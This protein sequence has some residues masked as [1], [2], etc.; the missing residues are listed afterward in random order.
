[1]HERRIRITITT[2]LSFGDEL[3]ADTRE[4]LCAL[5]VANFAAERKP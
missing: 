5:R 3:E 1:V 4:S 2:Q